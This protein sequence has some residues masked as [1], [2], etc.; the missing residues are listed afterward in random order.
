MKTLFTDTMEEGVSLSPKTIKTANKTKPYPDYLTVKKSIKINITDKVNPIKLSP[1]TAYIYKNNVYLTDQKGNI[2][3]IDCDMIYQPGA[4]A[5]KK[6]HGEYKLSGGENASEEN[7]DAGHFCVQLDQH[8]SFS[9]EQ[10]YHMNRYGSWR[11][12][13]RQWVEWSKAGHAVNVKGVFVDSFSAGTFSPF[14][15]IQVEVDGKKENEYILTN[16]DRQ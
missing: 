15:C 14:W 12:F 2:A 16:D 6:G 1:Q 5:L 8:P 3:Y 9:M 7:M 13:E 11:S 4:T 10:H